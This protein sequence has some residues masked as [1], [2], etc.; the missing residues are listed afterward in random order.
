MGFR[1]AD[2][3]VATHAMTNPVTGNAVVAGGR[4]VILKQIGSRPATYRVR[5]D[6]PDEAHRSLIIDDVTDHD[7]A[8][9]TVG[10][11]ADDSDTC[12]NVYLGWIPHGRTTMKALT[13]QGKRDVSR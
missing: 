10:S 12:R 3:V 2:A 7:I 4:G 1:E 11:A 9:A 8:P 5:F 6:G 13:W